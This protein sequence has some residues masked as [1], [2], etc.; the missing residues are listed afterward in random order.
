MA[1]SSQAAPRR[2]PPK[3]FEGFPLFS[4][5]SG[6]WAKKIKG[7]LYYF[8][9]WADPDAALVRLNREL[10]YLKDG[11]KPP[12]VDVSSGCTLKQLCNAFLRSKDAKL[13]AG[14]LSPRTFRDYYYTCE[15][16][17]E[18]FTK[19][20]PVSDLR[21]DDFRSY[22][23]QLAARFGPVS[24][25][26]EI[27]RIRTLFNYGHESQLI[28]R[29]VSFGQDFDCPSQKAIRR[30]R[31]A[32]GPRLFTRE[33]VLRIRDA[34][35]VQI[36]A[37]TLLG[38]N[39]GFGNTDCASLPLTGLDLETGWVTFP[40]PKT[41]IA[42]RVP[43]WPETVQAIK[44]AVEV[45]S[46]PADH[47]G[48]GLC[49]L[50]WQGRPWVRTQPKKEPSAEE[51]ATLPPPTVPLDALSQAFAKLLKKLHINGR[52]GLGFYTLRHCFE[53]QAGES[54]D[55]VAVDAIMGHVDASMAGAY[56][57]GISDGRLRAVVETVRAWLFAPVQEGGQG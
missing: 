40:R 37:M 6:Q 25:K 32:A 35:D 57:E 38:I 28:D 46:V 21:P 2:K 49:F 47:T 27:I 51:S 22:R 53:T 14:E 17:L 9:V 1:N 34:A 11:K 12:A 3:P 16:L 7:K 56:R 54:K 52:K 10:P 31:N 19:D 43:L 50:T 4:H 42:R 36:R 24:L 23:A 41:E 33:E 26:N 30:A 20:R 18:H 39:C 48:Q 29:P 13:Q 45:R 15:R 55:Q 44:E 8:G 5:P